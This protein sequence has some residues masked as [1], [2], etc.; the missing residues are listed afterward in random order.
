MAIDSPPTD[1]APNG[2]APTVSGPVGP[3]GAAGVHGAVGDARRRATRSRAGNA[4][5][6]AREATLDGA[7]QAIVKYGNR[8]ATMGDIAM[9]AGIAK[10]TLYNHFRTR[11]DVYR[12]VVLAE[13]EAVAVAARSKLS[14][15]LDV[16][17]ADAARLVAEHQALRRVAS[18][19]PAALAV[20]ATPDA[21]QGWV[22]ARVQ[23]GDVLRSAGVEVSGESVDLVS[24]YFA[25][26]VCD[27]STEAQR[28]ATT[29]MLASA[30]AAV[31]AVHQ[32]EGSVSVPVPV[33]VLVPAPVGS[34][35]TST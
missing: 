32:V 4:M 24:R 20:L 6:R 3:D 34:A 8:K 30:C 13:V 28:R 14:Q 26:L 35:D 27:P 10:A 19:D 22:A 23:I 17:L 5:S 11:D 15:G 1:S 2:S 9:L 29:A 18:D 21:S 12:A 7:V 25:S 33:P 31:E 16:A